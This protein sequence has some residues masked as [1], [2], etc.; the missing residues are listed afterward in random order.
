[1]WGGIMHFRCRQ[2]PH[3]IDGDWKVVESDKRLCGSFHECA[4]GSY[5]GSLF[6]TTLQN[7]TGHWVTYELSDEVKADK[8]R[9]SRI[10]EF[11]FGITNFDNFGSSYLTVFQCVTKEGWSDVMGMI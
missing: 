1:M 2:T 9:D 10:A 6:E 8:Y 4:P 11:N 5:C 7:E 3:P